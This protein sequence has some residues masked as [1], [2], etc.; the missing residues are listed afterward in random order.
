MGGWKLDEET[1]RA[2]VCAVAGGLIVVAIMALARHVH[3]TIS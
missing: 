3:V 1:L 2:L